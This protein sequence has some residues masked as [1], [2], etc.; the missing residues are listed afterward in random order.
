V[1]GGS[2]E[3][4][5]IEAEMMS[6]MLPSIFTLEI[7]GKPMLTFEAK[8]LREAH[9]L[10]QEQW[11]KIDLAEATSDGVPLWNGIAKLRARIALPNESA[12]FAEARNSGEPPDGLMLVYLVEL[13]GEATEGPRVNFRRPHLA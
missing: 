7:G 9:E 11:L 10:C 2:H 1:A 13:D 5:Q 12:L 8:N 6:N 4:H 3:D